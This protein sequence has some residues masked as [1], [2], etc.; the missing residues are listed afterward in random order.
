[1]RPLVIL[2]PEPGASQTA[3]QAQRLGLTPMVMPLFAIEAQPWT[4]PVED[5]FDGLLITSANAVRFGGPELQKLE[6][7]P[8][9]AVG[10]ATADTAREA[11]FAV[12]KVG[13]GGVNSLLSQIAPQSR[14]LH[15][16]GVHRRV[17]KNAVQQIEPIVVYCS[18]ERDLPG[19]LKQFEGAVVAVHSP[20]AGERLD[21]LYLEES[22]DRSATTVVAIS[23]DAARPAGQGWQQVEVASEPNDAALL[24]LA[25]RLCQNV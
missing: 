21:G 4:A 20:R 16:C 17:P 14:L 12:E 9:Y 2:R 13:S 10:E 7:L 3:E 25:A 8:V 19:N 6:G 22:V 24:A 15:L 1:M 23:E 11:G 5:A 18:V